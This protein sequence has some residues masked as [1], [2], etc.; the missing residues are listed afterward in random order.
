MAGREL[1][2]CCLLLVVVV[3]SHW[4]RCCDCLQQSPQ[5][6]GVRREPE[7]SLASPPSSKKSI[8]SRRSLW[9]ESVKTA[10][11]SAALGIASATILPPTEPASAA[12]G[13]AELDLEF[14]VRD[15]VGG[16]KKEGNILP[17]APPNVNPPRTLEG[18]LIPFLL[19]E[20]CTASC[21]PTRSLMEVLAQTTNPSTPTSLEQSIRDKVA[22]YRE[23]ASRSFALQKPWKEDRVSDQY[24]FDLTSYALWRTAADLI[25]N[26]TSRDKFV[27]TLGGNLYRQ[28]K[29]SK[30]LVTDAKGAGSSNNQPLQGTVSEI[31]QVLEL[32]KTSGYCKGYRIRTQDSEN[33]KA[34]SNNSSN[35]NAVFDELDEDSLLSGLSVDCL[36]SVYEP[37][38]LGAS[39]QITGEQSRF[40]P[41]YVGATLAAVWEANG[42]LSSWETLFVDPVYRPNP[43]DYYPDEKLFQFTLSSKKK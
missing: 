32:F 42:I 30:L 39:L 26:Y 7:Q 27:R 43:K 19:N 4:Q 33:D 21:V 15:L 37:A 22:T 35:N 20:D 14:Y 28:I 40:S 23:K 38:T 17:S 8:L 18:P 2:R 41:D 12:R 31:I 24:Y 34:G 16:N 1:Q 36:V 11:I 13:A 3:T 29:D 5:G 6:R 9:E 25:P 10:T